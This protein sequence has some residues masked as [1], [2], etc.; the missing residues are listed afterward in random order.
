VAHLLEH[1]QGGIDDAGARAVAAADALLEVLDD[2]VAVA[3]LVLEHRHDDEAQVA[4]LEDALALAF[5]SAKAAAVAVPMPM[6]AAVPPASEIVPGL[7]ARSVAV[8]V[9]EKQV[10]SPG[11]N[12]IIRYVAS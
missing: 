4:V 11:L 2:L 5:A 7:M 1:R 8:S 10:S 9:F 12:D 6:R 3:G